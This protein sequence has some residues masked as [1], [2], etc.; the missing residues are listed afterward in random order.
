MG[1]LN[2][3]LPNGVTLTYIQVVRIHSLGDGLGE[4]EW[5]KNDCGCCVT[6]HP[7]GDHKRGYVIDSDGGYEWVDVSTQTME[8]ALDEMYPDDSPWVEWDGHSEPS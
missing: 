3:T 2:I 4:Y 6:V 1:D 5:H 7:K 8:E